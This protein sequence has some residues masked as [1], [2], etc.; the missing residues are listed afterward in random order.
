M[1]QRAGEVARR[2]QWRVNM[3]TKARLRLSAIALAAGAAGLGAL[4]AVTPASAR[5]FVHV[6]FGPAFVAPVYPPPV[7]YAPAPVVYAP[8]PVVVQPTYISQPG[9]A[10][11][12]YFCDSPRGY[13]PYVTACSTAWRAVPA[14]PAR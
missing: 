13:Y 8:P 3:V 5:V 2:C 14:Q 9:A 12:W 11:T 1:G 4:A 7:V 10:S 6:G